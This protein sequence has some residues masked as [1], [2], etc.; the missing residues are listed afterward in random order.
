MTADENE[1]LHVDV[2]HFEIVRLE[3]VAHQQQIEISKLENE[4]AT[5][6]EQLSVFRTQ[7]ETQ[8]NQLIDA[9]TRLDQRQI[10]MSRLE[11][12]KSSTE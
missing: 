1:Q 8:E 3:T 12:E 11:N 10:E 5:L 6:N 2:L 4:K 7:I 9:R